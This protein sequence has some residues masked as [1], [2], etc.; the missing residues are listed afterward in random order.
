[1]AEN[2]GDGGG[3]KIET[4]FGATGTEWPVLPLRMVV[5]A[6]L[7][8]RDLRSGKSAERKQILHIT[9]QSFDEVMQGFG[10]KAFLDVPDRL[11][12]SKDPLIVELELPDLKAFKPDAVA[13]Q[14]PVT[15]DLLQLRA[16][17]TDLRTGKRRLAEVKQLLGTL[18]TRSAVLESVRRALE[19]GPA[20]QA[21]PSSGGAA[22]EP[23]SSGGIDSLLDMVEAPSGAAAGS[24]GADLA[25]LDAL[26]RELVR[27]ESQ[28]DRVDGKAVDAAVA[29]I[30]AALG[31]QID[32]VLHHPE[33]RRLEAA[34]R[35][36]RLLTDRTDFEQPIRIE[37]I[38]TGRDTLIPVYDELIH[39]PESQGISETPVSL[40][41][42]DQIFEN[43]PD[44]IDLLRGLA[45]RGSALSAVVLASAGNSLLG[46]SK[47]G[48]LAKKPGLRQVFEG[49]EFT[50]WRGLREYVHAR[51]LGLVFNRVLLRPAYG[52]E[53][54]FAYTE[55]F[56]DGDDLRP[57]GNGAW[58]VAS[59]ATRS[60]ARL[61]WCTDIMGQR[62]SGLVEDLAVRPYTRPGT[63]EVAFPLETA[64][65]DAIERDLSQSGIMALT[66]ALNSDRAYL[67]IAPSVHEPGHY[68]DPMD[69]ARARLQSTLPYQLFVGR[70]INFCMLI[71]GGLVPGR[72]P[73]QISAGY[74][75]A[76]RTLMSSAG[77]VPQEAVQVAVVPNADN[78][79]EQVL[80]MRITW[81]G[82][83]S[84]PDAGKLELTWP[85]QG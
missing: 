16:A 38:S 47:A 22:D 28:A 4:G 62:S 8:A 59:L 21:A 19:A 10:V 72:S 30:D 60:F 54:R 67:R 27:S 65:G 64:L 23:A 37:L 81:P 55:S 34:W 49:E 35:G 7:T 46:L 85:I 78:P 15:R 9:R 43:T 45:E 40:I 71:E 79:S 2:D 84:L 17:L 39:E 73:E 26:V 51:W 53:G 61:G 56:G 82:F 25:R 74:D 63:N 3:L 50:K 69:K 76:L 6:E 14:I 68:Q 41:L 58:A 12:G 32:T 20:P 11:S 13:E 36:L 29:E 80:H 44:D 24:H 1:M 75:Q 66:A 70:V 48:D 57:W 83:Q 52:A 33:F 18:E 42:V 5:L 77:A 31:S